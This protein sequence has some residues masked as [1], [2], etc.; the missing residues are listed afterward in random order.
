VAGLPLVDADGS[1]RA[2]PELAQQAMHVAGVAASPVVLTD[3]RGN[4]LVVHAADD[5]WAGALSRSAART[6][7]GVCAG[8]AYCMAGRVARES[9]VAGSISRAV[10]LGEALDV[11][12]PDAAL[13]ALGTVLRAKVVIRGRVTRV[14]RH[15]GAVFAAGAA[16]VGGLG[17]HHGREVRLELQNEFLLALQDGEVCA[18]VPDLIAL[19]ALETGAPVTTEAL[20]HGDRVAVVAA[21]VAD[22][23]STDAGLAVAGP[24]AF[25][26]ELDH[27]PV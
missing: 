9:V 7:G 27:A 10:R 16:T 12:D 26:Y 25:G 20:R 21:P 14:E 18:S 24:R 19:I 5:V 2:F 23:W 11:A 8:A 6:L 22:V 3:G 15:A 13:R 4:V 17:E 1:G